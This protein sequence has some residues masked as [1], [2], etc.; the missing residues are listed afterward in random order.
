M[1]AIYRWRVVIAFL[2]K[3]L[4]Q[5]TINVILYVVGHIAQDL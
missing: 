3:D 4:D 1:Y 5:L 2:V